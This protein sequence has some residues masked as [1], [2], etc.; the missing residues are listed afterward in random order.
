MND[1]FKN[2]LLQQKE[3]KAQREEDRIQRRH[4]M[5]MEKNKQGNEI[6][7]RADTTACAAAP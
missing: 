3:A 5:E 7:K 2:Q 6:T 1:Y 4:E